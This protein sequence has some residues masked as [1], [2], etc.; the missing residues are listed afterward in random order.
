MLPKP[1]RLSDKKDFQ[2]VLRR[3]KMH[4]ST[5]FGMAS[6][7]YEGPVKIGIIISNKISKSAVE[8]NRIKRVVRAVARD[9]LKK[10]TLGCKLVFLAK[11]PSSGAESSLISNDVE[12]LLKK[13]EKII[14]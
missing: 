3:G 4:H 7:K 5:S 8:R 11:K 12:E 2:E 13:N 10:R 9:Y 6:L 1:H 14:K